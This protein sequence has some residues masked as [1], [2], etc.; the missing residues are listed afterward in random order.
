[1]LAAHWLMALQV[2]F[3]PKVPARRKAAQAAAAGDAPSS[4]NA[5]ENDAF[6]DLIKAVQSHSLVM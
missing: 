6:K 1:M 2:K 5:E 3:V 4:S